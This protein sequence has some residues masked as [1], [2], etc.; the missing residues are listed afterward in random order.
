MCLENRN[1]MWSIKKENILLDH[2]RYKIVWIE[3]FG[4]CAFKIEKKWGV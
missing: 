1:K 4:E 2:E 3:N